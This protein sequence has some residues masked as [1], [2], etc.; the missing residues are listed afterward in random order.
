MIQLPRSNKTCP[1][2]GHG[3]AVFFQS[4]QRTADTGMVS[5]VPLQLAGS[6][7]LG[8]NND[9]RAC[10]SYLRN[11]SMCAATASAATFSSE[12]HRSDGS[13]R[14]TIPPMEGARRRASLSAGLGRRSLYLDVDVRLAWGV[15]RAFLFPVPFIILIWA[16]RGKT[17]PSF[18]TF[19]YISIGFLSV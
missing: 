3:E 11:C 12:G 1:S 17:R 10:F 16:W 18:Y 4:Q 15:G 2:C 13:I 19:T 14:W 6:S 7:K 9:V 5:K 8:S